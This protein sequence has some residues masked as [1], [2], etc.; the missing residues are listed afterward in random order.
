M[1]LYYV[2]TCMHAHNVKHKIIVS[3][4]STE[5]AY[6]CQRRC[7]FEINLAIDLAID[8]V[9]Q[10]DQDMHGTGF[11]VTTGNITRLATVTI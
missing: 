2:Y 7:S 5:I 1:S 11:A 6:H 4:I 8:L 3:G 9:F 10:F